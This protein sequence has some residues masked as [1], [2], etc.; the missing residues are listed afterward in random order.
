M[1]LAIFNSFFTMEMFDVRSFDDKTGEIEDN[2]DFDDFDDFDDK[3]DD[4]DEDEDVDVDDV[5]KSFKSV[6]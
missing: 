1:S 4:D 2:I 5:Y 6:T 3:D